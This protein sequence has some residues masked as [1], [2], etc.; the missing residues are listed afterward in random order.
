MRVIVRL[1]FPCALGF[2]L[3]LAGAAGCS[4]DDGPRDQNYGTDAGAGYRLPDAGPRDAGVDLPVLD[5]KMDVPPE[6]G[7]TDADDGGAGPDPDTA[8]S[9]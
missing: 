2:A 6:A 3:L 8:S 4:S 9:D 1:A 5:V 7:E